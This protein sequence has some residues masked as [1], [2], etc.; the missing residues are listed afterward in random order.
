MCPTIR[1]PANVSWHE[2]LVY[3]TIWPLLVELEHC[4]A[5]HEEGN[6]K[7]RTVA[8][9]GFATGTRMYGTA[10]CALDIKH[11]REARSQ[12]GRERLA[13]RA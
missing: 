11:F 8:L 13:D 3:N 12:N 2:D 6:D 4:N 9:P 5:E 1:V 7:I 10:K